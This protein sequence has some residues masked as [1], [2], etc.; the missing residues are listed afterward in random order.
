MI[1]LKVIN[2]DRNIIYKVVQ[3]ALSVCS[4]DIKAAEV[5]VL[6]GDNALVIYQTL[7]PQKFF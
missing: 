5:G 2:G 6:R 7:N 3:R 1:K 4:G